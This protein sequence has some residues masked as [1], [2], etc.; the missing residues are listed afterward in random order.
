MLQHLLVLALVCVVAQA[1]HQR[2]SPLMG[3]DFAATRSTSTPPA[4]EPSPFPEVNVFTIGEAG[5]YC[6][7]IPY[8]LVTRPR[9]IIIAWAE[10]RRGSCS[11]FAPTDLVFKRSFDNGTTWTALRVM[12]SD[13]THVIGNAAPVQVQASARP[14]APPRIVVPF[15]RDNLEV[16]Q[17]HSDDE[18]ETFAAPVLLRNVTNPAWAWIGT[19]PPGAIQLRAGRLVAPS[20]HSFVNNTDGMITRSHLMLND[21][22]LGDPNQWRLGA[23]VPGIFW[24]NECQ[25]VELEKDGHILLAARGILTQRIQAESL[26]GGETFGE[27]YWTSLTEPLGGCEGSIAYHR[28]SKTLLY[29]GTTNTN[30]ERY[31]MTLWSSTDHGMSWQLAVAVNPGKTGYSSLQIMPDGRQV[32]LLYER[33]NSTEFIFLPTH[34]SFLIVWPKPMLE[35]LGG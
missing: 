11:D 21:D 20:Y 33:S 7:K 35:P 14:G 30:P 22:P 25:A 2:R 26:D 31:N 1:R 15:C 13:G 12:H 23:F 10:A 9:G 19:G 5:Y 18:G 8:L 24:T 16:Y 4:Y 29:S 3:A 32:A 27:P 17:T 6:H 34:I 28:S